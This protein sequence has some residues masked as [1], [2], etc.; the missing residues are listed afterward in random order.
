M[1]AHIDQRARF[2]VGSPFVLC[3][4]PHVARI[5]AVETISCLDDEASDNI[6]KLPSSIVV[7]VIVV[8]VFSVNLE[9]LSGGDQLSV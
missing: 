3:L 9:A 8:Y 1:F 7:V 5:H 6:V 4:C 2:Q